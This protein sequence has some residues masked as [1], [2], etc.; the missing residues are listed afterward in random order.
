M[1]W[2][3]S[4]VNPYKWKIVGA[5][6]L[7]LVLYIGYLNINN[8]ILSSENE[9]LTLDNKQL[10][11]DLATRDETIASLEERATKSKQIEAD[12]EKIRKELKGKT[13]GPVADVLRHAVDADLV[14]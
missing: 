3:K 8:Y 14:R 11:T 7:A 6:G 5:I 10:A 12:Y 9:T 2:L 1:N 4:I 13:N